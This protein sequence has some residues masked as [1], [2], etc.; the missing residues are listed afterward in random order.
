MPASIYPIQDLFR[1]SDSQLGKLIAQAQ[2]IGELDRIFTS[3]LDV[4]LA[5]YCRVGCYQAGILTL[6]SES[7][8]YA[9]RLRYQIPTLLSQLRSFKQWAGLGTIQ[10]KIQTYRPQ[11]ATPKTPIPDKNIS[12][13]PQSCATQ[14]LALAASFKQKPDAQ[15]LA[16]SLENLAKHQ[17]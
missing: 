6:F 13:L 1:N 14:L 4:D 16:A 9:T 17:T 8:A 15:R 5:P 7:A 12:R 3:L 11:D 10:I 2:A